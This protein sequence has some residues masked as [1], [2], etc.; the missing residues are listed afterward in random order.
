MPFRIDVQRNGVVRCEK[1][2]RTVPND[3]AIFIRTCCNNKPKA[4]CSM[5]CYRVWASAWLRRQEQI[6]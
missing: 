1:C 6:A 3:R 2:G 4:F 5:Q